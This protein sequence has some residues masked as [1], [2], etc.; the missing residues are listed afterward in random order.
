VGL[1][2]PLHK[3]DLNFGFGEVGVL[4]KDGDGDEFGAGFGDEPKGGL[5]RLE[6]EGT[7]VGF[8]SGIHDEA[9]SGAEEE[10]VLVLFSGKGASERVL[11]DDD[12]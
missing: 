1:V 10:F 6:V 11:G 3:L 12:N 4:A 8:P 9:D 5:S 7:N 2:E